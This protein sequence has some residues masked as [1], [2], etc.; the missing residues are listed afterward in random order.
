MEQMIDRLPA[1]MLDISAFFL[2]RTQPV[3]IGLDPRID[4][5]AFVAQAERNRRVCYALSAFGR[6][7]EPVLQPRSLG[8]I[9]AGHGIEAIAAAY[10]FHR[11]ERIILAERDPAI[12]AQ[13][14]AN[15]RGNVAA[16]IAIEPYCRPI[17]L[18]D[19]PATIGEPVD[20]LFVDLM[21]APF[22]ARAGAVVAQGTSCP[23]VAGTRHDEVLNGHLLALTWH[24]LRTVR[25]A[26]RPG[27][28]ALMLLGGRFYPGLLE[29]LAKAAE[30]ELFDV[31][32][33]LERQDETA[34]ILPPF[35]AAETGGV[36][37]DF[38]EYDHR[39]RHAYDPVTR[40]G[41][42]RAIIHGRFSA[43][44][45]YRQFNAHIPVGFTYFLLRVVPW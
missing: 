19:P 14:V 43:H 8:L 32:C 10:A 16:D 24:F 29:L 17:D 13:A 28:F 15:I 6:S 35:V 25:H 34:T 45:A 22:S 38:Y 1:D 44:T 18:L 4:E 42:E 3:R 30:V 31:T 20:V 39:R 41:L 11:L 27:G 21:D 26:L 2:M 36:S 40:G 37:F 23:P 9:G 5:F 7:L 33:G 12:L